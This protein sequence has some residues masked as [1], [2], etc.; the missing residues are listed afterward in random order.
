MSAVTALPAQS[1]KPRNLTRP[2]AGDG[3]VIIATLI[4]LLAGGLVKYFY[5]TRT[6]ETEVAGISISY[7]SDW[8][9]MPVTGDQQLKAISSDG[10]QSQIILT[11]S[12]TTQP[13]VHL[14]VAGGSGNP[15]SSESDYSQ[16]SNSETTVDGV[17]AVQTDYAYVKTKVATS[18]VPTVIR[19]RQVAWIKDGKIY[20]L[21]IDGKEADWDETKKT[22]NRVVDKVNL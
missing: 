18:T 19:G 21:A 15:R 9:R 6:H 1:A 11:T 13:D 10:S 3:V 17:S 12:D 7:P 4:S 20:V 14:A 8:I 16:L 2:T 22:F 5:D